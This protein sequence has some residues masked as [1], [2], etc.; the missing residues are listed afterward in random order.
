DENA[1]A[2]DRT[3]RAD[4]KAHQLIGAGCCCST[5]A[6]HAPT[7]ASRQK[8]TGHAVLFRWNIFRDAGPRPTDGLTIDFDALAQDFNDR[9][10]AGAPEV[11]RSAAGA[12]CRASLFLAG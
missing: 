2:R 3:S 4:G 10:Y 7:L 9:R 5:F 8:N 12:V 6:T 11:G 1:L